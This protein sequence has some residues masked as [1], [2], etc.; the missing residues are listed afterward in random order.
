MAK[1]ILIIR[2][3]KDLVP[4]R[5]RKEMM[6]GAKMQVGREYHI[7]IVDDLVTP[8]SGVSRIFEFEVHNAE[9]ADE[10]KLEELEKRVGETLGNIINKK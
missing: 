3:N 6:D 8:K 7:F 5:Q 9:K 10:I 4:I 1:P 2:F